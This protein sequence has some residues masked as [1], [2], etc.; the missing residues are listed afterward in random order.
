MS[1]ALVILL[2]LARCTARPAIDRPAELAA[3]HLISKSGD[4]LARCLVMKYSWRAESAGPAKTTWQW[5]LDSIRRDHEAQVAAV[6]AQQAEQRR[7]TANAQMAAQRRKVTRW[8]DCI[9]DVS[10]R[11]GSSWSPLP[12][13]AWRP[14]WDELRD[15][16]VA[17]KVADDE[18]R[19]LIQAHDASAP[20]TP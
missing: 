5:H 17:R 20:K 10:Q 15:Y 1:R 11:P 19:F 9:L 6:L 4:E 8:V 3:C 2:L 18:I 7:R 12:C 13:Q 14:T 16:M